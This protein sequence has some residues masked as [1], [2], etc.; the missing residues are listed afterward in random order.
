MAGTTK[1]WAAR[2]MPKEAMAIEMAIV[3]ATAIRFDRKRDGNM[4]CSFL[5]TVGLKWR[6]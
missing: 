3:A 5:M 1:R 4:D 2:T 6:R